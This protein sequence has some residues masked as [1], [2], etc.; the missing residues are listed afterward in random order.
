[1]TSPTNERDP[2]ASRRVQTD[3]ADQTDDPLNAMSSNGFART[4]TELAIQRTLMAADRTLMAWLRTSLS[5]SGFG[6]TLYKVLQGFQQSGMLPAGNTPRQVGLFM[7]GV[8]TVAMV[9]GL[10]DH[11]LT[12]R[13]LR[14]LKPLGLRRP[15]MNMAIVMA[16]ASGVLFVTVFIRAL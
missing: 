14:L 10:I 11:V 6:F 12:L 4:R 15:A 16:A 13:T 1:M 5:T 9:I 7:I 3:K 8:G 2:V